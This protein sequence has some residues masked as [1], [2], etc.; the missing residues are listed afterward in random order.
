MTGKFGLDPH[1]LEDEE[2][3]R[4]LR[5]LYATRE[6]TFF[7]GSR[8]A[9]LNHTDRMLELER[10]YANRFPERTKADALRTRKGSRSRAGQ[11]DGR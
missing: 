5:H 6:E 11:P 1:R 2:L 7:H 8:Q 10:E 3:E 9:L 4:E